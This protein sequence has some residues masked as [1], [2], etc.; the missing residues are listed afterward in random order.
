MET[1][2]QCDADLAC[3]RLLDRLSDNPPEPAPVSV[4]AATE[5]RSAF[6]DI[7]D[8]RETAAVKSHDLSG[9]HPRRIPLALMAL[10]LVLSVFF[11]FFTYRLSAVEHLLQ[12]Q[13]TILMDLVTSGSSLENN[14]PK[15]NQV[16]EPI[17]KQ[18]IFLGEMNPIPDRK[19]RT[20]V[21]IQ[22]I[23]IISE[24][25]ETDPGTK[26]IGIIME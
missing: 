10:T 11:I 15:R 12:R 7:S 16:L 3:F 6:G 2:P 25:L 21:A 4:E 14:P 23:L 19:K 18:E 1:C 22:P 26:V 20:P 5:D 8:R 13:H 17:R 24:A 9:S